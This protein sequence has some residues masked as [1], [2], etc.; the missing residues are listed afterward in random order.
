MLRAV[1]GFSIQLIQPLAIHLKK[2]RKK[3]VNYALNGGSF[4]A[5]CT[6]RAIWC[7]RIPCVSIA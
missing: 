4:E 6:S 7:I 3:I 2:N 1:V 5:T